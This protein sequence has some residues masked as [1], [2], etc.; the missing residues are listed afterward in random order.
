[1][2]IKENDISL[3]RNFS[4]DMPPFY[5]V[6]GISARASYYI[7]NIIHLIMAQDSNNNNN[8]GNNNLDAIEGLANEANRLM[9]TDP[10][11][12]MKL[13]FMALSAAMVEYEEEQ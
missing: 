10:K 7:T 3:F 12:A 9:D 1:M 2:L 6:V 4:S 5:I 8:Q 11:K 13:A